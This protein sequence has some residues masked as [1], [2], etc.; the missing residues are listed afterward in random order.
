MLKRATR[1]RCEL[2]AQIP[3]NASGTDEAQESDAWIGDEPLGQ[4]K[5]A[6]TIGHFITAHSKEHTPA[7][8]IPVSVISCNLIFLSS[9]ERADVHRAERLMIGNDTERCQRI[10]HCAWQSTDCTHN[11]SF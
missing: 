4:L 7:A 9:Q 8:G 3:A 10:V 2:A 1:P 5:L 6:V 11:A